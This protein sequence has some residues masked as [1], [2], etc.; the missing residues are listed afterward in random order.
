MTAARLRRSRSGTV[1][2]KEEPRAGIKI[3]KDTLRQAV[4]DCVETGGGGKR[5]A[6]LET[7]SVWSC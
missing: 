1:H 7:D 2:C 5:A 6:A 3:E 4:E